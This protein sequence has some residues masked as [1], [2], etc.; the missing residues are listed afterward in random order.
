MSL[1]N[2]IS[3]MKENKSDE[4]LF[5]KDDPDMV[6]MIYF[7]RIKNAALFGD[8]QRVERLMK[9]R[10]IAVKMARFNKSKKEKNKNIEKEK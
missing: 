10:N 7:T 4:F 1:L 3:E 8:K 9:M 5:Y 6:E 2:N